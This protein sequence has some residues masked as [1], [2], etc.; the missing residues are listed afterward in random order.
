MP[1]GRGENDIKRKEKI[2]GLEMKMC[3][4]Y[5]HINYDWV[6]SQQ[7]KRE[8]NTKAGETTHVPGEF[9]I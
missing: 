5:I 4:T 6:D 2:S 7:Y 8:G 9:L 1:L 3:S